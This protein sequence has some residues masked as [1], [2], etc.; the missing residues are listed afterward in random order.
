MGEKMKMKDLIQSIIY[1]TLSLESNLV[2]KNQ[3]LPSN[4]CEWW[5]TCPG[6]FILSPQ[7]VQTLSQG[8]DRHPR[9]VISDVS[10]HSIHD[11]PAKVRLCQILMKNS[12]ASAIQKIFG[13]SCLNI[14]SLILPYNL[15]HGRDEYENMDE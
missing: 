6:P 10:S 8:T 13:Y 4:F 5:M 3:N 14:W 11:E 12:I 1:Q 9:D 2:T 7:F 15:S